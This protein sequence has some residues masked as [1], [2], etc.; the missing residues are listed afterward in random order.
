MAQSSLRV[1]GVTD[2]HPDAAGGLQP[3]RQS[4][5][6]NGAPARK[7]SLVTVKTGQRKTSFVSFDENR[8]TIEI[9]E[10]QVDKDV[11][12]NGDTVEDTQKC[13]DEGNQRVSVNKASSKCL[14]GD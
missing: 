4:P 12:E 8:T 11:K 2:H 5:A 14:F 3:Q 13:E 1:P 6:T 9:E 7:S 10:T